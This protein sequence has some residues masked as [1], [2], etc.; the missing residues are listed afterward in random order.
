MIGCMHVEKSADEYIKLI[1]FFFSRKTMKVMTHGP[2]F[3]RYGHRTP[4]RA[5]RN[6]SITRN[7]CCRDDATTAVG[8]EEKA[9]DGEV[10]K[11][12]NHY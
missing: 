4:N 8:N 2:R 9:G 11:N 5:V 1:I 7:E 12:I 3:S 6:A 10:R